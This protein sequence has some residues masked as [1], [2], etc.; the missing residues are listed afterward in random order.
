MASYELSS[1]SEQDVGL[2]IVLEPEVLGDDS[3]SMTEK[4]SDDMKD[5]MRNSTALNKDDAMMEVQVPTHPIPS[6]QGAFA[7]SVLEANDSPAIPKN[8]IGN[9]GARRKLLIDQDVS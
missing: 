8:T 3:H 9:A 4:L 5:S 7:E 2:P 6:M 1:S